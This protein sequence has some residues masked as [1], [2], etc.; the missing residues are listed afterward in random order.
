MMNEDLAFLSSGALVT[1]IV[2]LGNLFFFLSL[3]VIVSYYLKLKLEKNK[4]KA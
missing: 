3:P 1:S 2:I 4:V